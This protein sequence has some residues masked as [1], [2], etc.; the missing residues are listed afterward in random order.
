[1]T[2]SYHYYAV[3]NC[4]MKRY[5]KKIM[6]YFCKCSREKQIFEFIIEKCIFYILHYLPSPEFD[7]SFIKSTSQ[8]IFK[9]YKGEDS[10]LRSYQISL[11]QFSF[12]KRKK[13]LKKI[14]IIFFKCVFF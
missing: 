6:Q 14:I 5:L 2:A 10:E 9:Q 8:V 11:T 13:Q 7:S 12:S 1:M 4:S 3:L